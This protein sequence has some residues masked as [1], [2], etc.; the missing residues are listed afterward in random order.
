M[1]GK[2]QGAGASEEGAASAPGPLP[3]PPRG[4]A[5]LPWA[6]GP[7]PLPGPRLPSLGSRSRAGPPSRF[8]PSFPGTE[9]ELGGG[10][11]A[12]ASLSRRGGSGTTLLP[13]VTQPPG[14]HPS[15]REPG[16]Q[17]EGD[18]WGGSRLS[19]ELRSLQLDTRCLPPPSRLSWPAPAVPHRPPLSREPLHG[20][21][22]GGL[23]RSGGAGDG[24]T[25]GAPRAWL[26]PTA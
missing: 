4:M 22:V 24:R 3:P 9:T 18:K 10:R 23:C 11:P 16:S 20:A 12:G 17:W 6:L 19:P 26:S 8:L 21:P 2:G 1:G 14:P 13:K 5:G 25:A 7:G 15:P